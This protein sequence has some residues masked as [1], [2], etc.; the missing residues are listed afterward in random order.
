MARPI[1]RIDLPGH[2]ARDV[3]DP[4]HLAVDVKLELIRGGIADSDRP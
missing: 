1:V 4:C 3:R 2:H